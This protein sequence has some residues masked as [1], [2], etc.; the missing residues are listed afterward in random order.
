MTEGRWDGRGCPQEG[1]LQESKTQFGSPRAAGPSDEGLGEARGGPWTRASPVRAEGEGRQGALGEGS[2]GEG[3]TRTAAACG[4]E[5]RGLPG[6]GDVGPKTPLRSRGEASSFTVQMRSFQ[7]HVCTGPAGCVCVSVSACVGVCAG[8][9]QGRPRASPS[10]PLPARAPL[11]PPPRFPA[12]AARARDPRPPPPRPHIAAPPPRP[13]RHPRPAVGT[14][15]SRARP[16]LSVP[17]APRGEVCP[18]GEC[19]PW[20]RRPSRT[21]RHPAPP[22][23]VPAPR[24]PG[25]E[26]RGSRSVPRAGHCPP[27]R[28]PPGSPAPRRLRAGLPGRQQRRSLPCGRWGRAGPAA[29][30]GAAAPRPGSSSALAAAAARAPSLPPG[31]PACLARSLPPSARCRAPSLRLL[32]RVP[33]SHPF[34]PP[35]SFPPSGRP[36]AQASARRSPPA[37]ALAPAPA[38]RSRPGRQR[39]LGG[40][41][42]PRRERPGRAAGPSAL[43]AT[44]RPLRPRQGPRTPLGG[45]PDP[46]PPRPGA[47]PR[48]PRL[49]RAPGHS[50]PLKSEPSPGPRC[51][52]PHAGRPSTWR[53]FCAGSPHPALA[54]GTAAPPL[55][56]PVS[57]ASPRSPRSPWRPSPCSSP[58]LRQSPL[59]SACLSTGAGDSS[60]GPSAPQPPARCRRGVEAT[61]LYRAKVG[62]PG[63]SWPSRR[64]QSFSEMS[65]PEESEFPV[66]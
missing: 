8:G 31:P 5:A 57:S 60:A 16:P 54:A 21:R 45:G 47:G 49:G 40:P 63:S 20:L 44:S 62:A 66:P 3:G 17:P 13:P 39:R 37:A 22:A 10:G 28:P 61:P 34:S 1:R 56:G 2:W 4:S 65:C 18:P 51:S 14:G 26:L 38:L 32:R 33:P 58:D 9:R 30:P 7:G 15:R 19:S 48:A 35:S 52:P 53:C 24:A 12:P 6:C 59:R 55:P 11:L 42:A 41:G 46:A 50:E 29:R 64:L 27:R 43:G 23:T 36:R 25:A